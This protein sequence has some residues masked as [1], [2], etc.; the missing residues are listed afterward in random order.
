MRLKDGE[1]EKFSLATNTMSV[2]NRPSLTAEN[3]KT[4]HYG[5]TRAMTNTRS[6]PRMA[7]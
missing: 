3:A 6:S 2:L 1:E 5:L 4:A 7:L